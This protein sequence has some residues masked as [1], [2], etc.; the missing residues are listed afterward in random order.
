MSHI[1]LVDDEPLL[2]EVTKLSLEKIGGFLVT[3]LPDAKK[4]LDALKTTRYDAIVSDY[5]MRR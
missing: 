5:D 3:G 2:L 4:A 1:L